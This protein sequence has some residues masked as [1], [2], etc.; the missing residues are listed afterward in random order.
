MFNLIIF[1]TIFNVSFSSIIDIR[2]LKHS[3]YNT[4]TRNSFTIEGDQC[5]ENGGNNNY[6]WNVNQEGVLTGIH[7]SGTITDWDGVPEDLRF[8]LNGPNGPNI[9]TNLP[10]DSD[11][12]YDWL[13]TSID[14]SDGYLT[15][16]DWN[17][18]IEDCWGYGISICAIGSA[19][20]VALMGQARGYY[21]FFGHLKWTPVI[22]LGYF[23]SIYVHILINF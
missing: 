1:I 7:I 20:G 2:D 15:A 6:S 13:V 9:S 21:T 4:N 10:Y 11:G 3:K 16:G 19:A 5:L 14:Q 18:S 17:I 12:Y 22:A 23:A 8:N